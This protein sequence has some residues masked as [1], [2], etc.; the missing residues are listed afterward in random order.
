MAM[1]SARKV[2]GGAL[3]LAVGAARHA[4]W[5]VLYQVDGV[6]REDAAPPG[7]DA[8]EDEPAD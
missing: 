2:V 7:P 1:G 5:Y 6:T 8:S 4:V 3:V